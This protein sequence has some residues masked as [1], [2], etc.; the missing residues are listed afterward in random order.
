[1]APPV[2]GAFPREPIDREDQSGMKPSIHVYNVPA[3]DLLAL[4]RAAEEMGFEGLWLGEHVVVPAQTTSVHPGREEQTSTSHAPILELST[5]LHD[6]WVARG[7]LAS[8]T[9][10]LR[11]GLGVYLLPLRHPLLT[12]RAAASMQDF[13]GGRLSVGIGVGWLA[14]EFTALGVPFAGR[15]ARV[16]ETIEILRAAWRGGVFG[17]DG[18][19][20]S[21]E[22][23][24][25]SAHATPV[26]L[27]VGG[28]S[29]AGMARAARVGDGWIAS[30]T[31]SI[32]QAVELRAELRRHLAEARVERPF[33][34][35][36]R[37]ATVDRPTVDQYREH[38]FDE[39]VFHLNQGIAE[40]HGGWQAWLEAVAE[41]VGLDRTSVADR[42]HAAIAP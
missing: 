33:R 41:S 10:S 38:G 17:H 32:E 7:A 14:E 27:V 16:D 12:A 36:V 19:L 1:M 39:V 26:P 25:V 29:R 8:A 37:A 23:L 34:C 18:P 11:L 5:V 42:R 6:P 20:F 3:L 21:F 31:P 30:G 13:S 40:R 9:T 15:G 2:C 35:I 22:P 24:Q 28:N 4:A